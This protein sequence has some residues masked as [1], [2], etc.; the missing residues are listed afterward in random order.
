M[1]N[2]CCP[3]EGR[4][5][6]IGIHLLLVHHVELELELEGG[7]EVL[8]IVP[9]VGIDV[10]GIVGTSKIIRKRSDFIGSTIVLHLADDHGV[11]VVVPAAQV[12]R[13]ERQQVLA[14]DRRLEEALAEAQLPFDVGRIVDDR[15][16]GLDSSCPGVLPDLALDV[17]ASGDQGKLGLI[18]LDEVEAC[19]AYSE[20]GSCGYETDQDL[21][22]LVYG[23]TAEDQLEIGGAKC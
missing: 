3:F 11:L 18:A 12:A 2:Q 14:F 23:R 4:K 20:F 10:T 1:L 5:Q 21:G 7:A 15:V 9:Q 16:G 6:T 8:G 19:I 17:A 13:T 22:M